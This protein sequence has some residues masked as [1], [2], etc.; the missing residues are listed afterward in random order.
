MK[1][2]LILGCLLMWGCAMVP[3]QKVEVF[4]TITDETGNNQL[5][6]RFVLVKVPIKSEGKDYDFYSLVWEIKEGGDWAQKV[7]ISRAEFQKDCQRRRWVSKVQSFDP[8]TGHGILQIGEEGLP[9]S[10]GSMH[11]TYSWR[12]WDVL[13]N[14]EVRLIR[15]CKHP[16]ESFEKGK[17]SS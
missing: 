12:V 14:Q 10:A 16:F 9:D 6:L 15:V 3:D 11:V 7:A 1:R 5:V 17:A 13:N 2:S 8:G 4:R